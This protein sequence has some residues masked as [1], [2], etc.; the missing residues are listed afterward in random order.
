MKILADC[1]SGYCTV[2]FECANNDCGCIFEATYEDYKE[3]KG[4]NGNIL[5]CDC[6][7][8][9]KTTWRKPNGESE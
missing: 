2:I 9:R 5:L 4:R 8:C 6:P 3:I 1:K 7:K